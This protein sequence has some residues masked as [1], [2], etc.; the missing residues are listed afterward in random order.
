MSQTHT[1]NSKVQ[2]YRDHW[3]NYFLNPIVLFVFTLFVLAGIFLHWSDT[4]NSNA[5]KY[6]KSETLQLSISVKGFATRLS[7]TPHGDVAI[8]NNGNYWSVK[9]GSNMLGVGQVRSDEE[10]FGTIYSDNS[11]CSGVM[12]KGVSYGLQSYYIPSTT[13]KLAEG[14]CPA[15]AIG[16]TPV[17]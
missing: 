12:T 8:F 3:W 7:S 1:C 6:A 10:A 11:Y 9:Y 5:I 17:K 16:A 4:S 13:G 14:T 2:E 15:G